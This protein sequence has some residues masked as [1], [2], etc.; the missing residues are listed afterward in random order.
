MS[1]LGTRAYNNFNGTLQQSI[2]LVG[3]ELDIALFLFPKKLIS[4]L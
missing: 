3:C 2:Y 4:I 1:I